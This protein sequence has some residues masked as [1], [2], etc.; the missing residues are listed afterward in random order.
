MGCELSQGNTEL[1]GGAGAAEP[2]A[3]TWDQS[4]VPIAAA[5]R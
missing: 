5:G 1:L 2:I 3:L 4:G